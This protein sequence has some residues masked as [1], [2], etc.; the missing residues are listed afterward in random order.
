MIVVVFFV[1]AYC[2]NYQSEIHINK[3]FIGRHY[4]GYTSF[5]YPIGEDILQVGKDNT[6]QISVDNE[7]TPRGTLPLRHQ[8]RGW[9]NYGGI[10][11]DIYLLGVPRIYIEQVNILSSVNDDLR[12]GVINVEL[13][14]N[15]RN[16]GIQ[17]VPGLQI[18]IL[19]ELYDKLTQE[20]SSKSNIIPI[21]PKPNKTVTE[22]GI[23]QLN[24][25]KLWSPSNPNLYILK[26]KLVQVINKELQL[27]D[28]YMVDI[29]FQ[30]IKWEN[31]R[32]I[33]NNTALTLNGIVWHE[34]HPS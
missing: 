13:D 10:Y 19:L 20:L 3:N 24:D 26:C 12:T 4:G 25:P 2:I 9:R 22:K 33:L 34:D 28:E 16:S 17:Q 31:G 5:I 30:K 11:R 1:V 23:L 29:G 27:L 6:I 32:L 18:G 15:E 21:T 8:V 7:L 14:I